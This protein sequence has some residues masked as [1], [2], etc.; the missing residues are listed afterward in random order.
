MQNIPQDF[1]QKLDQ[2][3]II[4]FEQSED[5]Q[6]VLMSTEFDAIFNYYMA[7]FS[8]EKIKNQT[9]IYQRFFEL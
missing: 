8:N 2:L 4:P 3:P 9:E 7:N 1:E 6:R 5:F